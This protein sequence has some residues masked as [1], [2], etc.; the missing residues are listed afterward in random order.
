[1]KI[2]TSLRPH[3]VQAMAAHQ[4]RILTTEEI[5]GLVAASGVANFNPK[6]KR[7]RNLVNRELSDLAGQSTQGHGKPSPRVIAKVGRGRYQY[8]E[9]TRP[10]DVE[11][12]REYLEPSEVYEKRPPGRRRGGSDRRDV[13]ESVRMA[14]YVAQHGTCPGCGF[15]QPHYLRFEVDHIVALSDDGEHEVRNLQLLCSYC[16]RVKGTQGS[17]GFRMTMVELRAHNV[18]TGVMVDEREAMLTGRRLLVGAA[19]LG[20]E[21]DDAL[22]AVFWCPVSVAQATE[23]GNGPIDRGNGAWVKRWGLPVSGIIAVG[24]HRLVVSKSLVPDAAN[25]L[26][27][28]VSDLPLQREAHVGSSGEGEPDEFGVADGDRHA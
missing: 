9:P 6:A 22:T 1:M 14:L 13:P 24:M 21:R 18:A 25:H 8:R 27:G 26:T 12:L 15:H 28:K 3:I 16:N 7:D 10:M 20:G 11:L 4:G 17:Q 19:S 23:N 2:A 5:Y